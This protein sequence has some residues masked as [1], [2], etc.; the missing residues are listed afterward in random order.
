[1]LNKKFGSLTFIIFILAALVLGYYLGFL[2]YNVQQS[3]ANNQ[4]TSKSSENKVNFSTD[5][6]NASLKYF[7]GQVTSPSSYFVTD[8]KMVVSYDTQG[9]M[10]PPMLV[11]MKSHQVLPSQNTNYYQDLMQNNKDECI[12]VWG[13]NGE[14]SIEDWQSGI[15]QIKGALQNPEQITVGTRKA[16]LYLM[17]DNGG[18]KYVAF[19]PIGNSDE[20]SYYFNTC[21]SSN[22]S[23]FVNVIKSLK[24]RGDINF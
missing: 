21:N 13:T 16:M 12:L 11:L 17:K 2:K 15:L 8:D 22:K 7:T 1:M 24:L 20:T 10:A 18:D 14:T 5:L 3:P 19:L 23:D 6:E 4:Q 9:G